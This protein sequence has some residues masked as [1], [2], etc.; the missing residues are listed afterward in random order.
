MAKFAK[1][2][3]G[4]AMKVNTSALPDII[5][6]LLFFFM[7][8]TTMRE[9]ETK[10]DVRE[11]KATEIEKIERKDLVTY[12]YI[13]KPKASLQSAYGGESRVQLNDDIADI[14]KIQMFITGEREKM[15]EADRAKMTVNM[16]ID[17][18]TKM[19]LVTDVKQALRKAQAL[20]IM[21]SA[22]K[23]DEVY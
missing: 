14:G 12:M 5:F 7:V 19:G 23:R 11:V 15:K 8:S 1:K 16:K 22:Q 17:Q 9:T 13:G 3:A 10:V 4:G 6:M 2:K 20:L 21:Y 18:D